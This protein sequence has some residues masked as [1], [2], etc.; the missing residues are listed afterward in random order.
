[1]FGTFGLKEIGPSASNVANSIIQTIQSR[2][3]F[4]GISLPNNISCHW[5]I[6]PASYIHTHSLLTIYPGWRLSI[7]STHQVSI[8]VL[9]NDADHP[10]EG[11]IQSAT[12]YYPGILCL[13]ALIPGHLPSL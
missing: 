13:V 10:I 11:A 4:I 9:W 3:L 2:V 1:M 7:Y 6:P 8:G 12:D 5:N